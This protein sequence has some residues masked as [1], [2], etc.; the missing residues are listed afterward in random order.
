M[1]AADVVNILAALV[2]LCVVPCY[3]ISALVRSQRRC[4]ELTS[5][6]ETLNAALLSVAVEIGLDQEAHEYTVKDVVL[7]TREAMRWAR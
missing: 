7:R 6:C 2:A 1:S 5:R 3:A 4:E